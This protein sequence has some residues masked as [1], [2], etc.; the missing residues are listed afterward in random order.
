MSDKIRLPG[1]MQKIR[2]KANMDASAK[3]TVEQKAPEPT[4][5]QEPTSMV[6]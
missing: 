5:V 6:C 2:D 3:A 4:P 1:V